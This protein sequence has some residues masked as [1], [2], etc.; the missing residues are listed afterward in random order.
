MRRQLVLAVLVALAVVSMVWAQENT[1][2][3]GTPVEGA[4]SGVNFQ[5]DWTLST[6]SADRLMVQVER[7]GGNLIPQV[8]IIDANGGE[9]AQSYGSDYTYAA[10]EIDDF[11]LPS[12]GTY[13]IRVTRYGDE[14]G[15]T[16]G[17]YSLEVTPLGT[18]EDNPN[19]QFVI[20]DIQPDTPL[21][22]EITATHWRHLYTYTAQAGD[23]IDVIAR[24]T[25]GTL[26]PVVQVLDANDTALMTGYNQS[27]F[28]ET[29]QVPLPAAGTYTI[30][31][32]RESDQSGYT[33]GTYELTARLIGAGEGSP[34]LEGLAGTVVYNQPLTGSI[35]GERWYDD[36]QLT[37]D[38]SD[39]ITLN[40]TRTDGDLKPEVILLGG[41]GQELYH[42]YVDQTDAAAT[43]N[44]YTFDGAGS[45][46]VRV[47]RESGQTGETTG[48]YALTVTL[49]GTGEDSPALI[50]PVGEVTLG[51][52]VE[53]EI[54]N[55]KWENVWTFESAQGGSVTVRVE[56]TSGTL[57]PMIYIW[58]ANGQEMYS[59]YPANT[60]D[61][62]EMTSYSLPG[63]GT[64]RIVVS[65][66]SDQDGYT[67]GGYQL[68]VSAA[69]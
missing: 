1:L 51:E 11:T 22:G 55:A 58:D 8:S 21:D 32:S 17:S 67:V 3:Y 36:W 64:Y 2:S 25:G 50:E 47:S 57:S 5:E 56:R 28:A 7:T 48:A 43:I 15:E 19:N 14:T 27:A 60:R 59:A 18:A 42:G 12:A 45:Y 39:T 35:S 13:T 62:A 61:S 9:I 10:A 63:S 34:L 20:S 69:G 37:T 49:N 40:V 23:V 52:P 65:R 4:I 30:V 53:G 24:R 31:V 44:P 26:T 54:T 6:A 41:S 33:L 68:T 38:A 66:E 46:I 29:S 16:K